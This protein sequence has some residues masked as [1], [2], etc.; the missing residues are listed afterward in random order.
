[1]NAN[2]YGLFAVPWVIF[3][4]YWWYASRSAAAE[5]RKESLKERL[6]YHAL[7][8]LGGLLLGWQRLE[9][10][11]LG[12]HILPSDPET[13]FLGLGMLTAGLAFAIWA[14]VHLGRNWS[15]IVTIKVDHELIR[16][17][18]YRLVRHPIY[19]GIL[20]GILGTA[21]AF[22]VVR[23]FVA[24]AF[25]AL[26]FEI[27]LHREEVWLTRE[28]GEAYRAYQHDVKGLIPFVW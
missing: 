1:M 26:A 10:G 21:I 27:K 22:G 5:E 15:G 2:Y 25:Y 12:W 28:F 13:F 6:P 7:M 23:G 11:P 24:L 20:F 4:G 17:G 14:R 19:T 16:S 3:L 9:I 18:P 8:W